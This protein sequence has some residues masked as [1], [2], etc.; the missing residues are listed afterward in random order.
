MNLIIR[1][2]SYQQ[3]DQVVNIAGASSKTISV[4]L[5]KSFG[6]YDLSIKNSDNSENFYKFC[7]R[8]E[9]GIESRT[10]PFMGA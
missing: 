6:W 9:T 7:G 8:V 1:D 2:N 4:P 10:D 5:E 3:P